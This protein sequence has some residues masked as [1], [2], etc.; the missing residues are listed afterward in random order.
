MSDLRVLVVE[1]KQNW[2]EALPQILRRLGGEVQVDVAPSYAAAL[3]GITNEDYDLAI[4]DL[5]LLGDPVDSRDADQLGMELLRELRE[6]R[7]N[8][9]CGLIVLTAYP[10]TD[11]TRQAIRDYAADDFIEKHDFDDHHFAEVARDAVLNARLRQAGVKASAR[12]RLTVTFSQEFLV[13]SEL[14]G[15]DRRASY[16]ASHP[17]HFDVADLARRA[18]ITGGGIYI[19]G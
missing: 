3:Q 14:T 17:T 10:S 6:S 16:T 15:P 18:E 1:D 12:Y 8:Q 4:V 9:G 5:A 7:R 19:F 11:R 2:Q 13:G